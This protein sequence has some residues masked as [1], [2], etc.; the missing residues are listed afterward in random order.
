M[1]RLPLIIGI[2]LASIGMIVMLESAGTLANVVGIFFTF[3]GVIINLL[4]LYV[5]MPLFVSTP[6]SAS[7]LPNQA[8]RSQNNLL[9]II[10][11]Y[12][13][14]LSFAS[15]QQSSSLTA[16]KTFLWCC[17]T[18]IPFIIIAK[19]HGGG[20]VTDFMTVL[21]LFA[22]SGVGFIFLISSLR[23]KKN[24]STEIVGSILLTINADM[25]FFVLLSNPRAFFYT[26]GSGN[27]Y[28][29][30][31]F[32]LSGDL[33]FL[34]STFTLILGGIFLIRYVKAG[35]GALWGAILIM[36]GIWLI[37]SSISFLSLWITLANIGTGLAIFLATHEKQF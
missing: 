34:M 4:Q 26:Y 30:D 15:S 13:F 35:L 1:R 3:F 16:N 9:Q 25:L 11:Q 37:L 29:F 33:T 24:Q 36:I 8:N 18:F 23:L 21:L 6:S 19:F 20:L 5:P 7:A 31:V 14:S 12:L 32:Q 2:S 17:F 10:G 22:M 28:V 27:R